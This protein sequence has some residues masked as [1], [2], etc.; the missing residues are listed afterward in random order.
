MSCWRDLDPPFN[1][2]PTRLP[3]R[4]DIH[5]RTTRDGRT[6]CIDATHEGLGRQMYIVPIGHILDHPPSLK[7][8]R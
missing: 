3:D 2:C 1:P 6:V 7:A 4:V 8:G 5:A